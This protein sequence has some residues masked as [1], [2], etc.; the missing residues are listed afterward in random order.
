MENPLI[1]LII[2][3]TLAM[4][5]ALL[6]AETDQ[7]SAT[8]SP[9]SQPLIRE[10]T[11]AV[12]L[13]GDLKLRTPENEAEAEDLLS[14][15]Q[16]AKAYVDA[17]RE[18]AGKDRDGSG[19]LQY[20][21]RFLSHKGKKDGLYWEAAAGEVSSPLGPLFVQATEEGYTARKPGE[22]HR[23]YH[24]Y[25]FKIL[26]SQGSNAPGGE[27]DYVIKGRMTGGFGL[28][29]YPAGYGVSG[30]MTFMVNEDGIVCQKDLGPTTEEIA[31]AVTKYD[32]DTIWK[33]VK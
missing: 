32:P 27:R 2:L 33:Q 1:L 22:E 30:I 6:T 31:K 12:K 28:L 9:I 15:I 24:G 16:I 8:N 4:M 25:Y 7:P 13:A 3:I 20:A 18:Y 17:Q 23:P 5:P 26:K 29:A 19:I 21:Q 14:T 11:L 10:G